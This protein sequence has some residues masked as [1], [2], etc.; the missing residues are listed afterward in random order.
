MINID[1]VDQA[2]IYLSKTGLDVEIITSS[3]TGVNILIPNEKEEGDYFERPVPESMRHVVTDGKL[4]SG[5]LEHS[6]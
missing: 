6:G 5:I 3:T 4:T 1:H 2:T